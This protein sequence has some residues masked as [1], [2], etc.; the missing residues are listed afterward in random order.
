[1]QANNTNYNLKCN[2]CMTVYS[3]TSLDADVE[4]NLRL[5]RRNRRNSVS[6]IHGLCKSCKTQVLLSKLGVT[7]KEQAEELEKLDKE[8]L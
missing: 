7:A 3:V 6:V 1:M 5:A 8:Y 4:H 2:R